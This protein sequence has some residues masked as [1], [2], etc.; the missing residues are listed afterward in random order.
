[1]MFPP[2]T[3]DDR[4]GSGSDFGDDPDPSN[5]DRLI[6]LTMREVAIVGPASFNTAACATRSGSPTRW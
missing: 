1:M 3:G 6:Y 4:R 2:T 5:R